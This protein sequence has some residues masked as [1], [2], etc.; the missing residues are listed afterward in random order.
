MDFFYKL[1]HFF[2]DGSPKSQLYQFLLSSI[3]LILFIFRKTTENSPKP[4]S[5]TIPEVRQHD[6]TNSAEGEKIAVS[7]GK[8]KFCEKKR[9]EGFK[10][11]GR[12]QQRAYL[13]KMSQESVFI[14]K[15]LVPTYRG[16]ASLRGT[17]LTKYVPKS[18]KSELSLPPPPQDYLD[19]FESIFWIVNYFDFGTDPIPLP[20]WTVSTFWDFFV[21]MAPLQK[22]PKILDLPHHPPCL[23]LKLIWPFRPRGKGLF[24]YS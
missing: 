6:S 4:D 24:I 1:G 11:S 17:I 13:S 9:K 16:Q 15:G 7:R 5:R 22:F 21:W 3:V 19:C 10:Q 12:I 23:L 20:L 2:F 18:G 8:N 14:S